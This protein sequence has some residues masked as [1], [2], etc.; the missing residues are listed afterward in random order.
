MFHRWDGLDI[1]LVFDRW[2]G[3]DRL[4]FDKLDGRDRLVFDRCDGLERLME[5]GHRL[6][7]LI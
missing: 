1:L 6:S 5:D 7:L 4:V 2:G 3:R